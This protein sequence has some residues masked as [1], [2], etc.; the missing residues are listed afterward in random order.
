MTLPSTSSLASIGP[1]AI[2]IDASSTKSTI[3]QKQAT[4]IYDSYLG[5][6]APK[7]L[8]LPPQILAFIHEEVGGGSPNINIFGAAHTWV[9]WRLKQ[10]WYPAFLLS[11][12]YQSLLEHLKKVH[13]GWGRMLDV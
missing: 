3:A 9:Y 11:S 12:T 7:R 13:K 6:D 4:R 2:I 1:E 8:E 10:T 5:P